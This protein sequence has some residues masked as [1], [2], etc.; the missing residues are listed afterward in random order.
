MMMKRKNDMLTLRDIDAATNSK[1][2]SIYSDLYKEVYGCRPYNPTFE[3]VEE[4]DTDFE[5]LSHMLNKQIE[6]EAE[7]QQIYFD[8]FVARVEETMQIVQGTT[9]ERAIEIIAE[10]EGIRAAEFEF[11]GLEI[12]E[13]ELNLK[14]G[15]ISKWLSE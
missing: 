15:S 2:G 12:L 14:F 7:Y 1:D 4:F 13:H 9:R 10:A 3:S 8:K 11:Y 6:S 5:A